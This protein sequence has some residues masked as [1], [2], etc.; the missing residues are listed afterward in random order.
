MTY[1]PADR[2]L[3]VAVG[4]EL[5]RARQESELSLRQVCGRMGHEISTSTLCRVENGKQGLG[6]EAFVHLCVALRVSPVLL[7]Q[8]ACAKAY[9]H[10]HR[11]PVGYVRLQPG[12]EIQVY[13]WGR[14]FGPAGAAHHPTGGTDI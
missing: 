10:T 7:L 5:A 1:L 14:G 3:A 13:D 8:D 4:T 9:H 11:V 12:G 6:L 2:D